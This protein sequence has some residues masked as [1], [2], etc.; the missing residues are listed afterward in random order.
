V[1]TE[2]QR[3]GQFGE[4]QLAGDKAIAAAST[5]LILRSNDA[6]HATLQ[7]IDLDIMPMGIE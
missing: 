4:V 5:K 1:D 2:C 6:T 7:G 3:P